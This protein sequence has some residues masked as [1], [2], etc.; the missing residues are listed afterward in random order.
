MGERHFT[1]WLK[2][3][4]FLELVLAIE[5]MEGPQSNLEEKDNP[6]ILKDNFSSRKDPSI[7]TSIA[8]DWP[9]ARSNKTSPSPQCLLDETQVQKLILVLA[10]NQRPDHT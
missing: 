5:I 4:L 3:P 10:A 2:A 9:L 1:D 8:L 7:F 6:K